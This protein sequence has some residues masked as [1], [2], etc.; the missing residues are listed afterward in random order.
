M[1]MPTPPTS[2]G[3]TAANRRM[4]PPHW[5]EAQT[6]EEKST[7][8]RL[9]PLASTTLRPP[10]HT[11]LAPAPLAT[12]HPSTH[13][14]IGMGPASKDTPVSQPPQNPRP[15]AAIQPISKI[16][17][18][19][20]RKGRSP[21]LLV[22]PPPALPAPAPAGIPGVRGPGPQNPPGTD[23]KAVRTVARSHAMQF[24]SLPAPSP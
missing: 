8:T 1:L 4:H 22:V 6:P 10:T 11:V 15:L 13:Q 2:K 12:V 14:E 23:H 17:T 19:T 24:S 7:P 16:A 9:L 3:K 20:G 5:A 18:S 21:F